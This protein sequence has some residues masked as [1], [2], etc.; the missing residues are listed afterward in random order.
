MAC[1]VDL[2]TRLVVEA[3]PRHRDRVAVMADVEAHSL[4]VASSRRAAQSGIGWFQCSDCW[5]GILS[6]LAD[7]THNSAG[8]RRRSATRRW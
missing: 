2:A 7:G 5:T 8:V 4:D 6:R 1:G 3:R